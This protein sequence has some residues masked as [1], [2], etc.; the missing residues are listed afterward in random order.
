MTELAIFVA[1][2]IALVSFGKEW[3][4]AWCFSIAMLLAWL[5][6]VDTLLAL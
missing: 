2:G 6:S 3:G 4:A 5:A 1:T